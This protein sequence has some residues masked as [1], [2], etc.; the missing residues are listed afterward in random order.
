MDAHSGERDVERMRLNNLSVIK[1][2]RWW[3]VALLS[4]MV[5]NTQ[6]IQGGAL[7]LKL[8]ARIN[9]YP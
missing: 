2:G 3:D 8:I 7:Y 9:S 5:T 4:G 1:V 6:Q